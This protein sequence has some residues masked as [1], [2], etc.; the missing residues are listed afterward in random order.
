MPKQIAFS[1]SLSL[2]L[3]DK[4]GRAPRRLMEGKEGDY[5]RSNTNADQAI[6]LTARLQLSW[7]AT[8]CKVCSVKRFSRNVYLIYLRSM[9]IF[10]GRDRRHL[11]SNGEEGAHR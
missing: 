2:S 7:N 1:L 10:A 4:S 9:A 11:Y 8:C 5:G 3:R 6:I